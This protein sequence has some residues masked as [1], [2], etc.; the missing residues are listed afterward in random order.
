MCLP[1]RKPIK[2]E[3][4]NSNNQDNRLPETI[5]IMDMFD[6]GYL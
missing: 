6:K 3:S 1:Y 2:Q 5:N 4:W